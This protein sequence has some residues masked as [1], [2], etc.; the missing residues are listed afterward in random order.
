ME[1]NDDVNTPAF[2]ES[3]A[4]PG[5]TSDSPSRLRVDNA[6]ELIAALPAMLGFLPTRSLVVPLLSTESTPDATE[7]IQAVM[8][9]DIDPVTEPAGTRHLINMLDAVCLREGFTSTMM[10]IVDDRPTASKTADELLRHLTQAGIEPS[11]AWWVEHICAGAEYQDL[12]S[13]EHGRVDDPR[14]S[15]VAC[16]HVLDGHQIHGSRAELTDLL[17]Q[18]PELTDQ[19]RAHLDDTDAR[20]RH[21]LATATAA[22]RAIAYRRD[23][24][25][26]VFIQISTVSETPATAQDLATVAVL[27]RDQVVRDIMYGLADTIYHGDAQALWRQVASVTEGTDRA[28]AATL[29]GYSAYHHNN[30][31]VAGIAIAT[32]LEAD[33]DLMIANLL[34]LA[35][36]EC[37]RP[38]R[39][40]MMAECGR[41]IAANVGIDIDTTS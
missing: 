26:W 20:Y 39:I 29:F 17:T 21:N 2:D 7:S 19:V 36:Q 27:L 35:M 31:V 24:V 9:F 5:T 11:H 34:D 33:P 18:N 1:A 41:E 25:E 4:P 15:M 12:L 28:Q 22:N 3:D 32:A 37:L 38:D 10:I 16:A 8:R 40:R 23:M 13:F 30:T 6:G 14:T